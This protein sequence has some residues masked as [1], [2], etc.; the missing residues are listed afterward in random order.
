MKTSHEIVN[1]FSNLIKAAKQ[2]HKN[3]TPLKS[4]DFPEAYEVSAFDME[5]LGNALYQVGELFIKAEKRRIN[6]E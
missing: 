3:A 6:N 5:N 1:C 4:L 2:I